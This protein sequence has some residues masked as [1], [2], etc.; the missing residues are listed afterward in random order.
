MRKR[1]VSIWENLQF[2]KNCK[3]LIHNQDE[4]LVLNNVDLK[5]AKN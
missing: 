1:V 2:T 4:S 5:Y 3:F